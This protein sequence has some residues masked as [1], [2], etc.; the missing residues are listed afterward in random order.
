M[1][2]RGWRWT[3]G[4]GLLFGGLAGVDP[5]ACT[6][7]QG[8]RACRK[9]TDDFV[10]F[11]WRRVAYAEATAMVSIMWAS[12]LCVGP[13]L[14]QL[15]RRFRSTR[16]RGQEGLAAGLGEEGSGPQAAVGSERDR[17]GP[18]EVPAGPTAVVWGKGL[19]TPLRG[20]SRARARPGG[21]G[22][23]T[24]VLWP[25]DFPSAGTA[26]GTTRQLIFK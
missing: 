12:G 2:L 24:Q 6:T 13:G 17:V 25:G 18:W 11:P 19:S 9:T 10:S 1:E 7:T 15:S 8:G 16:G 20:S 26:P 5:A 22:Y 4:A 14:C 23:E 21:H 3:V